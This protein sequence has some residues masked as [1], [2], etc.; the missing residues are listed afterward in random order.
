MCNLSDLIEERGIEK[1]IEKGVYYTLCRLIN[2]GK[3]TILD[4]AEDA[5]V[6]ME[7]MER[8]LVEYSDEKQI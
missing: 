3:I 5:G 2:M 6:S 1:G 8:I 7:E 4:A